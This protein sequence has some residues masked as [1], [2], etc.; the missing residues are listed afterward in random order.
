[1]VLTSNLTR[2]TTKS[3]KDEKMQRT[4]LQRTAQKSQGSPEK[5]KRKPQRLQQKNPQRKKLQNKKK[6]RIK[7]QTPCF[8]QYKKIPFLIKRPPLILEYL[9]K[10][11][12]LENYISFIFR[13]KISS[14]QNL[15]QP[16][17]FCKHFL[18]PIFKQT[19]KIYDIMQSDQTSSQ[20]FLLSKQMTQIR[21]TK[22]FTSIAI[23]VLCQWT[24]ISPKY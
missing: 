17:L 2:K 5:Q 11:S 16:I 15:F 7:N 19:I 21:L 8:F 18:F 1:M 4:L 10:D 6:S 13:N 22:I 12:E 24:I 20:S 14:P 9:K 3:L 23:T